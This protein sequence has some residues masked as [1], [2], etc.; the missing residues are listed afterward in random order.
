MLS[1]L[2][3]HPVSL[4]IGVILGLFAAYETSV[5]FLAYTG[6]AYVM[7]DIIV[8]SA[9]VEGPVSRLAVQ[10]NQSVT[11]DQLL[12][13]IERTPYTLKLQ[14]TQAALATARA[15]LE[16]AQDEVNAAKAAVISAQA[17][18]TN[19]EDQLT[20]IKT[21]E[22]E[23]Y[24]PE[25]TLDVATRDVATANAN[26]TAAGAQLAVAAR[27]VSVA[28][29]AI[30]SA[31]A[32]VAKAQYDLS[33]TMI[34][35]PDAGRVAPFVTRVGDYLR[36]GSEVMAIVTDK[37]RRVVAN[38]SE[39][40]LARIRVG[41][42]ALLTLGSDPWVLHWGRVSGIAGGVARSPDNPQVIPYVEP[43]TDWV[44]LPRRFPI[45]VTLDAWP[46]GLGL[47]NGADARVLIW[48]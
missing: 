2:I 1:R 12:F 42:R 16:L 22:K 19:A 37:R 46:E 28:Q 20:R 17:V 5:R 32:A 25:A 30:E 9:Q 34:N 6:D 44:R 7:S 8:L 21:L 43:T 31:A 13:E 33:K 24:S 40:H 3:R 48:F 39:R 29:A 47:F 18:Q 10:N 15:N 38:V 4:I 11:A 45:E 26:V 23:G 35:A 36:P 27:R 14:E 41:Q